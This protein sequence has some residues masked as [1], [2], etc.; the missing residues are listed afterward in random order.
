MRSPAL[1]ADAHQL[2]SDVVTSAGVVAGVGLVALTGALWLDPLLAALTA[3]NILFSGFRLLRE[4]VGGL[5]DA[6]S[7]TLDGHVGARRG[8]G[9]DQGARGLRATSTHESRKAQNFTLP[10]LKAHVAQQVSCGKPA[11]G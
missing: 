5:M 4:S 3:G 8:V 7:F 11:D 6:E 1:V 10:Q 9:A 2:W